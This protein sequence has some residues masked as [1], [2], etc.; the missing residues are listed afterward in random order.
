MFRQIIIVGCIFTF[1]CAAMQP[2]PM[3]YPDG[4]YNPAQYSHDLA[5]CESWAEGAAYEGTA[6]V[7]DG[8]VGGAIAGALLS[9][10]LGA[11][12]GAMI[13]F[14]PG[15]GAGIGAATGAYSG[16]VSGGAIAA[17]ERER[18][19]KEAVLLCLKRHGYEASY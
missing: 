13:G 14:D 19:R 16:G 6:S 17:S 10:G 4:K 15:L 11:I 2:R 5:G 3:V 7:G 18:R 1:G 9:A 12:L 8:V